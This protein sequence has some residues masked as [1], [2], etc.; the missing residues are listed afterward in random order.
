MVK[1]RYLAAFTCAILNNQP[2]GFYAPAVLVKDAQRHGLKVKPIDVQISQW[3]CTIEHES[4]G[5]L[6]LR[7]G[8]NYAKKACGNN[9]RK[10]SYMLAPRVVYFVLRKI[11]P[12]AFHH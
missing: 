6:S 2:M 3:P 1:V 10:R 4:D 7:M 5:S 12:C 9:R 8:L 11:L